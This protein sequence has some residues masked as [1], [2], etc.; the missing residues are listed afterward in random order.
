MRNGQSFNL[1]WKFKDE[2]KPEYI[3]QKEYGKKCAEVFHQGA[4]LRRL[5]KRTDNFM[6]AV[7]AD[8]ADTANESRPSFWGNDVSEVMQF[9]G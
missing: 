4:R 1:N 7:R 9:Q 6:K 3:T 8:E 5:N 2:F